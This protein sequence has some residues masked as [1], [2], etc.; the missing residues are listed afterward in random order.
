[1]KKALLLALFALASI[2]FI[3]PQAK[4]DT[5]TQEY[6][7]NKEFNE[8]GYEPMRA[9]QDT[10]G[11][12]W[13]E[14]YI[15]NTSGEN[16]VYEL[17]AGGT[18]VNH[19]DEIIAMELVHTNGYDDDFTTPNI[20]GLYADTEGNVWINTANGLLIK[21]KDGTP[22]LIT[23]QSVWEEI[24]GTS[25]S[26]ANWGA[27]GTVFGDNQGNLYLSASLDKDGDYL[28]RIL[29]R[30]P[31][32]TWST[33]IP[34]GGIVNKYNRGS[35]LRGAYNNLTGDFWFCLRYGDES[36]IYRYTNGSWTNYTT[37]NGLADNVVNDVII[38]D[39]GN[40]YAHRAYNFEGKVS[41][42]DG[43]SWTALNSS[44]SGLGAGLVSQITNDKNGNLWFSIYGGG[45]NDGTA[46]IYNSTAGTWTYYSAR[47]GMDDI[48]KMTRVFF[49][50]NEFWAYSGSQK[51]FLI[52]ERN[53][54]QSTLYGQTSGD[55]VSKAGFDM[56]KKK[57]KTTTVKN[58]AVTI[59]RITRV[60]VKK[61]WKTKKTQV[62]KTGATQWYKALNLD[63]GKYQVISKAKGKK[64]KTRTINI[65][66]GDPYRLD[67]RY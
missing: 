18:W 1:M 31:G 44:N 46:S 66:S 45:E 7:V 51:G 11:N 50:G 52:I 55:L 37:A 56:A 25:V 9:V 23:P 3:V 58:K 20:S 62:Y 47:N 8:F 63:T 49:L 38:D 33:A 16:L 10:A 53:D 48:T 39:G 29:K 27:F 21:Y 30:T 60:K 28:D 17:T 13:F 15:P 57:K 24:L 2:A 64:K 43:T 36:G 35:K 12:K 34:G 42:F 54:S 4:A 32:G 14:V 26:E 59:Y 5:W 19:S 6:L 22:T 41:K 67:L 61:K 40:V 65:T